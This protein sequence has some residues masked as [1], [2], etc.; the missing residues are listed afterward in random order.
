MARAVTPLPLARSTQPW[1]FGP[2]GAA[3]YDALKY[4]AAHRDVTTMP[5]D[6]LVDHDPY[7]YTICDGY[8]KAQY[9]FLI[10]PRI[11]FYIDVQDQGIST[12]VQVPTRD[13][14]S[15]QAL[16]QSRHASAVLDRLSEARHR[17]IAFMPR[18]ARRELS[19]MG[20]MRFIHAVTIRTNMPRVSH[21][22]S[23]AAFTAFLL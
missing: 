3:W 7:T 10:L 22:T 4:I 6:M 5:P 20:T 1:T 12:R 8:A 14:D 19:H 15:I 17:F 11:P 18:C 16:L 9:H 23:I 2:P 21:G 13:L